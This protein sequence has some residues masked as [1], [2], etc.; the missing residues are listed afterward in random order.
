[1][2]W[3]VV[4]VAHA[5]IDCADA[6]VAQSHTSLPADPL[7]ISYTTPSGS[8]RITL[9]GLGYRDAGG[10]KDATTVTIGGQSMSQVSTHQYLDPEG[11]SI[12]YKLGPP[13]GTNN[14]VI[15]WSPAAPLNGNIII[16][17]CTGVDQASPFRSNNQATGN[18]TAATVTLGTINTGDVAIDFVT[19]DNSG[20]LTLGANQTEIAQ[21][22]SV[23]SN[24]GASYQ[25]GA[26]GGVMSWTV[27]ASDQWA[28]I[29][30]ALKPASSSSSSNVIRRRVN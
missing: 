22:A 16:W 20:T 3:G 26:D 29:A 1:M 24:S 4:P 21:G 30:A 8:D 7:T 6:N 27:A 15:D 14:V 17:T 10:A 2:C 28:I 25:A 18:S 13:S 9:V 23:T 11:A 12:Y 5:A 19:T